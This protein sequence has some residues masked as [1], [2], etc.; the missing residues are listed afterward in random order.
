M[1]GKAWSIDWTFER[2]AICF[3]CSVDAVQRI[4]M[5][6]VKT[7]VTCENCGAERVYNIHGSYVA[8]PV[9]VQPVR[10]HQYDIWRFT[11]EAV[12][13][14][15]GDIARHD[16]TIDE[17]M[18]TILCPVCHFLRLYEFAFFNRVRPRK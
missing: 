16:V 2:R 18:A 3:N 4:E 13:P 7:T 9:D 10:K 8:T 15:H 5:L 14:N 1:A 11:R 12:C 17:Y 6:P